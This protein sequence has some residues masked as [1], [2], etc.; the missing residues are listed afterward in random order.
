MSTEELK[1]LFYTYNFLTFEISAK[2]GDSLS[3]AFYTSI[4]ML[5][6]FEGYSGEQDS[7]VKQLEDENSDKHS[8]Y[9]SNSFSNGFPLESAKG[10]LGN[11]SYNKEFSL[12]IADSELQKDYQDFKRKKNKDC[13]C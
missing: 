2:T 9:D 10:N 13:K 6:I 11:E 12:K 8:N 5:P 3:K 1:D 4:S 7:I